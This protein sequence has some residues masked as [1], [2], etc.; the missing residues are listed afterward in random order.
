MQEE[1]DMMLNREVWEVVPKPENVKI[2]GNRWVFTIKRN[3]NG[4]IVRHKA[5]LVAQGFDQQ[6]GENY[7]DV[8]SPVVNF[9]IIRLFFSV[10]VC[11]F[12]WEHCQIDIKCA[13]LY[14]PLKERIFMKQ[15]KG[16]VDPNKQ[17]HVC[18]LKR[19][20][21]GLHQSGREWFYEIHSVLEDLNFHTLDWVNCVYTFQNNILLLLYV[22][23]IVIFGRTESYITNVIKLLSEKFDLKVLG[24]TRKLLG[25]EFEEDHDKL[26][27]H[28][29]DYIA[30]VYKTYE[31]YD[32]PMA[33]LPI[34]QGVVL[35]KLQC[36][37]NSEEV[38]EMAELPYRNIIGCL[39]YIADR[40]RP[41]ISYTV[42]I[43]SQFQSN[44]GMPHW[45]ALLKL[46]GYVNCTRNKKL[47][48]S[49]I[50]ELNINCYSDASFA[51]NRD[52]RTSMTGIILFMAN[53]PIFWK[54]NKQKCVSLST[55]ESEYV[56]LTQAAKE[57][58]WVIRILKECEELKLF[59]MSDNHTLYCDNMAAIDF[60]RSPIEN[61]KTK[62]IHV[63]YHFLRNLVLEQM[64]SLKYISGKINP[65]DVFTKAL[66]KVKFEEFNDKC[67]VT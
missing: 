33:S 18:L 11:L 40:T 57:L 3:E 50:D 64:F 19:A 2:L 52:D 43:L 62:H 42:N 66:S 24:K 60:S 34:A 61:S 4:E 65:A 45:K 58:M 63:K 59:K 51:S 5:R 23:D 16:F 21:Y 49:R 25:V 55:L 9:S 53:S 44:P 6:K 14:A 1:I 54:S 20:L 26:Y 46:L 12:K 32:I 10:L 38:A 13:Y 47:E 31:K 8:F 41:D 17:N 56:A 39:A 67:F 15:P 36:P 27:I 37:T 30:K 28:Q 29:T 35:S 48:L 7:E 22:D